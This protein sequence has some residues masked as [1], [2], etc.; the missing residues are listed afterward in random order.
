VKTSEQAP[1]RTAPVVPGWKDAIPA[2]KRRLDIACILLALPVI[3]PLVLF[4]SLAIKLLS[5]GPVLFRQERIGYL[6]R[7]FICF[8]FRS[9]RVNASADPH[10]D[11]YKRLIHEQV[12]M[13]KMDKLG[14]RRLF[15]L[16]AVLRATG[17]DELPQLY[18]VLRGEMSLVGPRPCM[19]YEYENYL[20]WHKNRFCTLPGLTGLWQVSGKNRTTFDEMIQLDIAYGADRSLKLDLAIM[21]K[22]FAVVALQTKEAL[23]GKGR[24]N[25]RRKKGSAGS[26]T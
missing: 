7:R 2:W 20:P 8:K 10:A 26:R 11:Y 16:G 25:S 22:T 23:M 6:G 14:D 21:L 24:G 9:M 18:N 19:P 13:T 4:I 5:R 15:P 17:L 3:L 1:E 12:P